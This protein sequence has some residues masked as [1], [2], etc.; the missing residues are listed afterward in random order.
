MIVPH[1]KA[2]IAGLDQRVPQRV[3]KADNSGTLTAG[4]KLINAGL[5]ITSNVGKMSANANHVFQNNLK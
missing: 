5:F 3:G 2:A 4:L 1:V